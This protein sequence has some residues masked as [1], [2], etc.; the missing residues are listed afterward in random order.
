VHVPDPAS[1]IARVVD[2][3]RRLPS[4]ATTT[5][6][7][8]PERAKGVLG[9]G[10]RLAAGTALAVTGAALSG[11]A[12]IA[13]SLLSRRNPDSTDSTDRTDLSDVAADTPGAAFD[14][15]AAEPDVVPT[16]P[17]PRT[18]ASESAPVESTE[19]APD[20]PDDLSSAEAAGAPGVAT[21]AA[22]QAS[23][24]IGAAG[25]TPGADTAHDDLPLANFDHMTIG[26]L[27]GHL[28]S[29]DLEQL[30]V[31]RGYEQAHAHRLQVLTMLENRIAKLTREA[32]G[33][34]G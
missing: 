21:A 31:L 32:D 19:E 17:A 9:E 10:G 29:L 3:A 20:R 12:S 18:R 27:R 13:A 11:A 4:T 1:S 2:E 23:A 28:R 33:S 24:E 22:E 30:V 34:A 26:S 14:R 15:V 16:P 25:G 5:A 8:L 6:R 7:A